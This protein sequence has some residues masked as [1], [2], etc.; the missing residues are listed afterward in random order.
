M[1][2]AIRKIEKSSAYRRRVRENRDDVRKEQKFESPKDRTTTTAT[3]TKERVQPRCNLLR[4]PGTGTLFE[5]SNL[6]NVWQ[7]G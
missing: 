1:T 7:T 6:S 5:G 3:T 4:V 2:F